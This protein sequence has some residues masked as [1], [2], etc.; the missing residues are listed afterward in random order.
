MR[1]AG[2][3]QGP[4]VAKREG[5]HDRWIN[6]SESEAGQIEIP[7]RGH[8]LA[9]HV[10]DRVEVQPEAVVL[11]GVQS[12]TRLVTAL[13][14]QHLLS[15]PGQVRG[16]DQAVRAAADHDGVVRAGGRHRRPSAAPRAAL[17][18]TPRFIGTLHMFSRNQRNGSARHHGAW[19]Q[20]ASSATSHAARYPVAR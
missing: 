15:R 7:M 1:V 8:A 17:V 5:G 10:V 20:P 9:H 6:V 11:V 18:P 16:A 13:E 12:A 3:D 2:E 4:P 14:Q 19:R